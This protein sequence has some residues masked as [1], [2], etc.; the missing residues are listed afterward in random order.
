MPC[1]AIWRR[2]ASSE[3]VS[4][5]LGLVVSTRLTQRSTIAAS[6]RPPLPRW[7]I[8]AWV[9]LPTILW[10][11]ERTRSA[12]QESASGGSDGVEV[13]VGAPG[14]VDDQRHA[15]LVGD[16]G[17]AGDVGAG[18]EVGRRDDHR[19]DRVRGLVQRGGERVRGE[20]VGDPELGVELRR[21]ECRVHP[22]EDQPVDH[23]GVDVALDDDALAVVGERHAGAV[24]ALR[25]A[26]DQEPGPLRPPGLGGQ[27]LG[28]LEG[29]RFGPEV[30]PLGDRGDVVAQAGLADQLEHRRVGA[31]RRPC[32]RGPG[33]G[34]GRARSRR[35][36]RRRREWSPGA[37][38]RAS[39]RVY[40][41]LFAA[42]GQLAEGPLPQL[43][44]RRPCRYWTI[45]EA[46]STRD[47]ATGWR[48]PGRPSRCR[49]STATG[50]PTWS[51]SGAA[52]PGSGPPGTSSSWSRTRAWFCSRP[53][54][55]PPG[56]AAATAASAT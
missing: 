2:A 11:E 8:A 43:D 30:D 21:D 50:T 3:P 52:S 36:A 34:R 6:S 31:E 44:N 20:A 53:R 24:V 39:A 17:E 12:P 15:A 55:A 14:L 7:S 4:R 13:Q 29:R 33:S 26:V 35:A 19:R 46:W 23:R 47:T 54:P 22:V 38:N 16:L 25:G 42:I 32:G 40:A 9:R 48:R 28:L 18:A 45:G 10:V 41:A 49:R 5:P 37:A 56:R 27:Q 51:S 1:T